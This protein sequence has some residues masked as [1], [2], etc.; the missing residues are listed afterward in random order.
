MLLV[1]I[2]A[3]CD[4]FSNKVTRIKLNPLGGSVI[5]FDWCFHIVSK[6][7][8]GSDALTLWSGLDWCP[9]STSVILSCDTIRV[10]HTL[11]MDVHC[12]FLLPRSKIILR[13]SRIPQLISGSEIWP[14]TSVTFQT[15][16]LFA[17]NSKSLRW[18]A[19]ARSIMI[20]P[21]VSLSSFSSPKCF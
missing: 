14:D 18:H 8:H 5:I 16:P 4:F 10:S 3:C 12:V 17:P 1:C 6:A 2:T 9:I 13:L 15:L 11:H 7:Q 21:C 20:V 19:M